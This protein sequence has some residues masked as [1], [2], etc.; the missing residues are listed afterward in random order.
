MTPQQEKTLYAKLRRPVHISYIAH[1]LKCGLDEATRIIKD[2]EEKGVVEEYDPKVGK[3]Y[4]F[5]KN[6]ENK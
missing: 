6:T 4:Y 1:L 5:I 2:L 3:G